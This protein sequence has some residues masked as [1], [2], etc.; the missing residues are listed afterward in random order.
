MDPAGAENLLAPRPEMLPRALIHAMNETERG[1]FEPIQYREL[2][3]CGDTKR[4]YRPAKIG[5]KTV[6]CLDWIGQL[7]IAALP[8]SVRKA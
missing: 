2:F 6:S 1:A 3:G 7:A 8:P 5:P 4:G